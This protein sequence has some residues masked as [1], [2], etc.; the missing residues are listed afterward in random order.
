MSKRQDVCARMR[1]KVCGAVE[2]KV[3]A[4]R[5]RERDLLDLRGHRLARRRSHL[6]LHLLTFLAM[7]FVENKHLDQDSEYKALF[8]NDEVCMSTGAGALKALVQLGISLLAEVSVCKGDLFET[9]VLNYFVNASRGWMVAC[10]MVTNLASIFRKVITGATQ[11]DFS[12]AIV[13]VV[14]LQ[15]FIGHFAPLAL[16]VGVH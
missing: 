12:R 13:I 9:R 5:H 8:F 10:N 6:Y 11:M 7:Y 16:Q 2:G 3:D 15:D 4:L 14:V 1:L